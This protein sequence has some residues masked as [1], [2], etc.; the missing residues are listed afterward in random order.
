MITK[1]ELAAIEARCKEDQYGQY[2][3][4][5]LLTGSLREIGRRAKAAQKCCSEKGCDHVEALLQDLAALAPEEEDA[6]EP[7]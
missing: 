7:A 4:V 5:P 3:D 1:E 6:H 2:S